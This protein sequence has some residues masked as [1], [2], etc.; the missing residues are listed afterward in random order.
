MRTES[1]RRPCSDAAP[2]P[3]KTALAPHEPNNTQVAYI[4]LRRDAGRSLTQLVRTPTHALRRCLD[5]TWT[6]SLVA[7][8][9]A[10]MLP[11]SM[12]MRATGDRTTVVGALVGRSIAIGLG[13]EDPR[14]R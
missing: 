6:H 11:V 4:W 2:P 1:G 10:I 5:S 14:A 12:R 3:P 13:G 7:L 8:P 9:A